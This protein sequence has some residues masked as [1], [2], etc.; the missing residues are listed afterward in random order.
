MPTSA[1]V[2]LGA[3]LPF[4]GVEG[5]PLLARAVAAMRTDG[6]DVRALS[7]VWRTEAWPRCSGQPDYCNAVVELDAVGFHPEALYERLTA[8]ERRFG[9]ERRERWAARTLDLDIIAM[10]GF[11]GEFGPISLPH[12]RMSERAFVLAPLAEVAPDWR[13]PTGR[14]VREMLESLPAGYRCERIGALA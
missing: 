7:G 4:E 13:H 10:Q 14:S 9:R 12:P 5:A 3:N 11:E 2:A 8:I 1:F 6:L